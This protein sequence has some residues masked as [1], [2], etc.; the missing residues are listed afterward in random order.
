MTSPTRVV[1]QIAIIVSSFQVY[2]QNHLVSYFNAIR[3]NQS[4]SIENETQLLLSDRSLWSSLITYQN[5]SSANVRNQSYLLIARLGQKGRREEDRTWAVE[6]LIKTN[7]NKDS[8]IVGLVVRELSAFQR[9]DFTLASRDSLRNIV[10]QKVSHYAS[11]LRL[12]GYVRLKDQVSSIRSQIEQGRLSRSEKWAAYLALSRM[13][14]ESA[15][16]FVLTRVKQLKVNDEV[17]YELFPDLIYTRQPV[18]IQYLVEVLNNDDPLCESADAE[19][20]KPLTCGYRI[21][22]LLAPVIK[23]FPI[24]VDV[25]G[26]L[27]VTDYKVA[28][29]QVRAWFKTH[30]DYKIL[31]VSL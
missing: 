9:E 5:D 10:Q 19:N 18:P 4:T 12:I 26:D 14:D 31:D 15:L 7:R 1:V 25:S 17:V 6:Q 8:G 28:L 3:N 23:D 13:G 24:K 11:W 20:A 22:E 21:M 30:A 29:Q 27:S 2:S 16:Q